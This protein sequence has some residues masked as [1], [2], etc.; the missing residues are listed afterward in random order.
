MFDFS[1]EESLFVA[2]LQSLPIAAATTDVRG[3]IRSINAAL[4]A[5]TGYTPKE[6][7][8]QPITLL[9]SGTPESSFPDI[10]RQAIRS[11]EP[12]RG[13]RIC[14]RKAGDI[15]TAEQTITSIESRDGQIL[16]VVVTIQEVACV[17][18]DGAERTGVDLLAIE[19]QRDFELFFNLIP[20]LACIV[21]T[22]GYF[23]KVNPAWETTLGYTREEVLATPM[24]NRGAE[25]SKGTIAWR[26]IT[27]GCLR[28]CT[29]AVSFKVLPSRRTVKRTFWPSG[30]ARTSR[31]RRSGSPIDS[32]L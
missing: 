11:R 27:G 14:R 22:D 24:K 1:P 9:S 8:G 31:P 16:L 12:W 10:I 23:K 18:P 29:V 20:D 4:T 3:T 25:K 32:P 13:E 19:A 6:T 26:G 21:S 5:L 30:V 28:A 17:R 15:F 7:V 2:A